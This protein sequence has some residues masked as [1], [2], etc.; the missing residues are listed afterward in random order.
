MRGKSKKNRKTEKIQYGSFR[1]IAGQ[2]RSRRLKFPESE[3]LRPSTD[4]VRE[5]LFNWLAPHIPDANVLDL[6]AG[7]GALGLEALS[8]GASHLD[9][10][11]LDRTVA[12][13]LDENIRLLEAP[14]KVHQSEALHWLESNDQVFDLVFVDPPFRK[15]LVEQVLMALMKGNHLAKQGLIYIEQES[16]APMPAVPGHWELMREK[17]AGQVRYCLYRAETRE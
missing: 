10:I 3:G 7:S 15:G 17:V 11:E 2:W 14:A 13:S 1:I 12:A 4:R 9:A 5:T 6:F 8:R 16:E